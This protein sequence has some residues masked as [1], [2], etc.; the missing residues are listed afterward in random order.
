MNNTPSIKNNNFNNKKR[1]WVM[2]SSG[3][4]VS[5]LKEVP[6]IE[7]A[8]PV[9]ITS[10]RQKTKVMSRIPSCPL[11]ACL[12]GNSEFWLRPP[13]PGKDDC[14]WVCKV[15]HPH[16]KELKGITWYIVPPRDQEP[17]KVPPKEKKP[18]TDNERMGLPP[19]Y[20]PYPSPCPKCGSEFYWPGE[21]DWQCCECQPRPEE[22]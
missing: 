16:P 2:G 12:C 14:E 5:P 15:C 7:L 18:L 21:K 11:L 10:P 6:Q 13:L 9:V 17:L 3:V 1:I 8:A 20:P 22:D 4:S 19:D